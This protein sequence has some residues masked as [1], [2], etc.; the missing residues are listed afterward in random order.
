VSDAKRQLH[1]ACQRAKLDTTQIKMAWILW[2]LVGMEAAMEFVRDAGS[3]ADAP[4]LHTLD[5][6]A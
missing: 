3:R 4:L 1:R 2:Q 6:T 5:G